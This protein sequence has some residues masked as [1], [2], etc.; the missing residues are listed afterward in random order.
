MPAWSYT[1]LTGFETCAWRHYLTKVAKRVKEPETEPLRWGN[2]VHKALENYLK[3]GTPLPT[4]LAGYAPL[5]DRIAAS[6]ELF[7]EREAALTREFKPSGWWD[8]TTWCRSKWDVAVKHRDAPVMAIW[9]WKTGKRKDD[10]DQMKLFA[11]VGFLHEP[12][13]EVI[14][15]GF[16]WLKDR[17]IDTNTFT[18]K[19]APMLWREYL[20]RVRRFELAHEQDN[21]P[22]KPSGLCRSYCPVGRANCEFC[23]S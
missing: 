11:A 21:W 2:F 1:A 20:P 18:R 9:D 4:T 10:P 8:K 5:C 13:V 12:S 14:H 22:K 17:K 7:V 3:Q 15:T 6:G 19:E 23:G 16:V